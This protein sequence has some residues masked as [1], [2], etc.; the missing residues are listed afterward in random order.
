[1]EAIRRGATTLDGVKFRTRAGMG[2]CQGGFC[3]SYVVDIL[4]RELDVHP[5]QIT[6]NGGNSRVLVGETK[7]LLR[8]ERKRTL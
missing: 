8:A 1:M 7:E 4:S 3:E 6:K 2:R 5:A